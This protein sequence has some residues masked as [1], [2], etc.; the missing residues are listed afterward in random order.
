[1][2]LEL[3][4]ARI[5]ITCQPYRGELDYLSV[6][7]KVGVCSNKVGIQAKELHGIQCIQLLPEHNPFTK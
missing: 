2:L 6:S 1:M 3:V 7:V 5:E 4:N